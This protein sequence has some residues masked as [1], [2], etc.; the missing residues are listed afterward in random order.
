M[1]ECSDPACMIE[2]PLTNI[3]S[4]VWPL[5]SALPMPKT[6][7]P[8]TFVDSP[9]LISVD[10][11]HEVIGIFESAFKRLPRLIVFEIL[12]RKLSL[13]PLCLILASL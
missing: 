6:T 1:V 9:R 7:L 2:L 10:S 5:H 13:N 4:V 8:L 3:L 12:A 11:E